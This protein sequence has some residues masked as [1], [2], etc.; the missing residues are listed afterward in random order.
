[1]ILQKE[2]CKKRLALWQRVLGVMFMKEVHFQFAKL[3]NA[4][5]TVLYY[6]QIY[7]SCINTGNHSFSIKVVHCCMNISM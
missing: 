2:E 7:L 3:N 4:L 6:L 1:M 5:L